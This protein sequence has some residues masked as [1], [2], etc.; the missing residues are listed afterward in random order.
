MRPQE[1]GTGGVWCSCERDDCLGTSHSNAAT[2]AC[3]PCLQHFLHTNDLSVALHLSQ[4]LSPIMLTVVL[5]TIKQSPITM[6]LVE[7]L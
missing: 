2:G 7:G 4:Q 1:F 3:V 5:D 6:V